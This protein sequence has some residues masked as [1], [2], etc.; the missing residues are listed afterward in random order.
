MSVFALELTINCLSN[1]AFNKK[2]PFFIIVTDIKNNNLSLQVSKTSTMS[3]RTLR[4]K[5]A[6]KDY[7][8]AIAACVMALSILY[9]L[10]IDALKYVN[11][12]PRFN[13][14]GIPL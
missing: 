8:A 1:C 7:I 12:G 10:V 4:V 5:V 3:G 6:H 2:A 14:P 13:N 9:P 11:L